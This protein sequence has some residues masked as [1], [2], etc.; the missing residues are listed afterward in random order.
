MVRVAREAAAALARQRRFT[1]ITIMATH[2]KVSEALVAREH[3]H[4]LLVQQ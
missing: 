3:H 4:Q 1:I 2:I